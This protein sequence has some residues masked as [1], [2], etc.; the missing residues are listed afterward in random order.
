VIAPEHQDLNAWD[1]TMKVLEKLV[2]EIQV[3]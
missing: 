3:I 1:L 2:I